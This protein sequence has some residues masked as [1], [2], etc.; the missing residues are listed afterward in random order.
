MGQREGVNGSKRAASG[1]I[2]HAA[3][4]KYE[5]TNCLVKF[6]CSRTCCTKYRQVIPPSLL[7]YRAYKVRFFLMAITCSR[8]L[9]CDSVCNLVSALSQHADWSG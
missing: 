8:A 1:I 3:D 6:L 5:A 7:L 9:H 4:D 2:L